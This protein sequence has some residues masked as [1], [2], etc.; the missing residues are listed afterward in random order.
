MSAVTIAIDLIGNDL[1][2]GA[3]GSLFGS[4]GRL[5]G[6]LGSLGKQMGGL[7][8]TFGQAAAAGLGTA[9]A[10]GLFTDGLDT[11]VNAAGDLQTATINMSLM[12]HGASEVMPE[13]TNAIIDLADHSMYSSSQVADAFAALG[14]HLITAQQILDG[15]GASAIRL[16]LAM[17]SDAAPAADLLGQAMQVFS[18][19]GY[20]S[21]QVA[22]MLDAAFHNGIPSV[23]GL[24]QAFANAGGMAD[25]VGVRMDDFLAVM[26]QLAPRMAS[27]AQ[28][29]TS[30]RYAIQNMVHPIGPAKDEMKAL[31]LISLD[32]A[33][34][35]TSSKFYDAQGNFIGL[36]ASIDVIN[37]AIKNLNPE[38][39]AEALGSLFNVRSGQGI[40]A[41]LQGLQDV[42]SS[43][44]KAK[45]H[46]DAAGQAQRDAD[47]RMKAYQA[48]AKEFGST[49]TD[50]WARV[51]TSILPV[52]TGIFQWVNQLI[53]RFNKAG[54]EVHQLVAIFLLV[55]AVLSGV[56]T[57]AIAAL[58]IIMSPFA[59]VIGIVIGAFLAV[60]AVA[61]LIVLAFVGLR[62]AITH[63]QTLMNLWNGVIKFLGDMLGVLKDQGM[64]LLD[65][66][67]LLAPVWEVL[68]VVLLVVAGIIVGVVVVAIA[69]IIAVLIAVVWIITNAIQWFAKFG[70]LV[71]QV[72]SAIGT[73]LS[74]V[75]GWFQAAWAAVVQ[76]TTDTWNTIRTGVGGFFS[77]LGSKVQA[78]MQA[79]KDIFHNAVEAVVGFFSWL[80]NHNYYFQALVDFIRTKFEQARAFIT[81]IWAAITSWLSSTW[82]N[83]SSTASSIFNRVTSVI[84][85]AIH[86]A[87]SIITSV[88]NAVSGFFSSVWNGIV[89]IVGGAISRLVGQIQGGVGQAGSAAQNIVSVVQSVIGTL[90][91]ILFQ[92]GQNAVQMLARGIAAAA[93]AVI[94]QAQSIADKVKSLLG[95]H[96][97][98][99]EG[100]L[101]DSDEYMPNMMRM[102]AAGIE[103][104]LPLVG[105][106][107]DKVSGL[108]SNKFTT[109]QIAQSQ[110]T[111]LPSQQGQVVIPIN[112]DGKQIAQYTVNIVDKKIAQSGGARLGR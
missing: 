18:D 63:N 69:I 23:D 38:Q 15:V 80:Y 35:L 56:V 28:A 71:G 86:T 85:A 52:L 62:D 99:K 51:G 49:L 58:I 57:A 93:G 112:L 27:P 14:K 5:N 11:A 34:K 40:R 91:G 29:A 46:I 92:S 7:P 8:F 104:H 53:D 60:I 95:F 24:R 64:K 32:A 31:G 33:G 110:V 88:W 79:V 39:K 96:S 67:K 66:L 30:L 13:L 107:L 1:S 59:A 43:Y 26:D 50:A 36:G 84:S 76:F 81:A 6:V 45:G 87:Q 55:G 17:G 44:D 70:T 74:Q 102:Y 111:A 9:A 47:E 105:D 97:P 61:G 78:G 19:Q 98:P 101:A 65:S 20:T 90:A 48:V 4:V 16:A 72:F 73:F 77:D 108:I 21:A 37:Q 82:N 3:F 12:V 89:A 68:K 106:K 75:P 103:G 83:I 100:P 109:P 25:S 94:A 10:F 22:D 2:A 41:L 54:P 42:S